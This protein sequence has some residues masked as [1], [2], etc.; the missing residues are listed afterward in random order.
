MPLPP[1]K[2]RRQ[3]YIAESRCRHAHSSERQAQTS[4]G[5]HHVGCHRASPRG[6]AQLCEFSKRGLDAMVGKHHGEARGPAVCSA[7]LPNESESSHRD[8]TAAKQCSS[9]AVSQ[10]PLVKATEEVVED[11]F[12]QTQSRGQ[13]PIEV[14]VHEAVEQNRNRPG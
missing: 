1:M 6:S 9:V 10:E 4:G 14:H 11:E 2:D 7:D 8:L 12:V 13:E 3:G 5:R